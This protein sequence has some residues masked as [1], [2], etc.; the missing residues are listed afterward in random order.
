M[1]IQGKIEKIKSVCDFDFIL[2]CFLQDENHPSKW[3]QVYASG[4]RSSRYM[5]I[6]VQKRIG[7]TGLAMKTGRPHF[8]INAEKEIQKKEL[9]QYPIIMAEKL[10]SL[11]AV[12]LLANNQVIGVLLAGFRSVNQMTDGCIEK[13]KNEVHR[14]FQGYF[15]EE[16]GHNE[17][18]FQLAFREDFTELFSKHK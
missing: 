6:V 11:G 12:P 16:L 2:L 4:N 14:H 8:I 3:K 13:F 17:G 10:K 1:D 18:N 15:D 5:R 7:L 9:T